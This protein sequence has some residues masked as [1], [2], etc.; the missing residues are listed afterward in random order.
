M[1]PGTLSAHEVRSTVLTDPLNVF[2][3]LHLVPGIVAPEYDDNNMPMSTLVEVK[4]IELPTASQ[5]AAMSKLALSELQPQM[6]RLSPRHVSAVGPE[7]DK[8]ITRQES[9]TAHDWAPGHGGPIMNTA[10]LLGLTTPEYALTEQTDIGFVNGGRPVEMERRLQGLI[11][12]EY[13]PDVSQITVSGVVSEALSDAEILLLNE[14]HGFSLPATA[15]QADFAKALSSKYG[16]RVNIPRITNANTYR[17]FG[18]FL[19]SLGERQY[20]K[21][22][23]GIVRIGSATTSLYVGFKHFDSQAA[24]VERKIHGSAV[25]MCS[26]ESDPVKVNQ[27]APNTY[28]NEITRMTEAAIRLYRIKKDE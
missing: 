28:L 10:R 26:V 5:I 2:K 19:D 27:R 20:G 14:E 3:V 15:T 6:N 24:L 23:K 12:S 8:K 11:G 21:L 25:E 16:T 17:A 22:L 7:R 4:G 1:M 9:Q 18:S 13:A